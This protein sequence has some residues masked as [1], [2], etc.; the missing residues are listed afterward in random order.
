M[1]RSVA[2]LIRDDEQECLQ[3][4][5]EHP[6]DAWLNGRLVG[7]QRARD[8]A[9]EAERTSPAGADAELVQQVR[10]LVKRYG[11]AVVTH[12]VVRQSQAGHP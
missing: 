3:A 12:E 10:S 11:A 6:L 7:L 5:T 8:I 9:A 2:D 4:L 1:I